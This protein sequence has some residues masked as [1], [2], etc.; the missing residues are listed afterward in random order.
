MAAL[1]SSPAPENHTEKHTKSRSNVYIIPPHLSPSQKSQYKELPEGGFTDVKVD[2][3]VGEIVDSKQRVWYFARYKGGIIRGFMA[4][5]F[6]STHKD[7]IDIYEEKKAAGLL[8]PF[9]PSNNSEVHPEHRISMTVKLDMKK[10][11]VTRLSISSASSS[12]HQDDVDPVPDSDDDE[13][14]DEDPYTE[15]ESEGPPRRSTRTHTK[16]QLLSP[17][18]LRRR[19]VFPVEDDGAEEPVAGTSLRRSGRSRKPLKLSLDDDDYE[20]ESNVD[21]SDGYASAGRHQSKAKSK[22]R[23][24]RAARAAYGQFRSMEEVDE[25]NV[26]PLMAHRHICE[27]CL[28]PPTTKLLASLKRKGKAKSRRR[29]PDEEDESDEEER[30]LSKGGWVRCLKCPVSAH[31]GCLAGTQ[32][33][34][35]L[36]AARQRDREQWLKAQEGSVDVD[37]DRTGP[38]KR[39]SL[40]VNQTTDFI[41]GSCMKG[42]FCMGCMETVLEPNPSSTQPSNMTIDQTS[43]VTMTDRTAQPESSDSNQLLFRCLTCKRLAHYEH[44]AK[45]QDPDED[46]TEL[47]R[48]H[49]YNWLCSDCVSYQWKLDK[50]LA[51]RPYPPNAVEPARSDTEPVNYKAPLPRQYLVKWQERGYR[52]TQWVPHMWLLTTNAQKLR[53]FILEG[54]K[55]KLLSEPRES[56]RDGTEDTNDGLNPVASSRESSVHPSSKTPRF[57]Q[58]PMPDAETKIPLEWQTIDRVLDVKLRRPLSRQKTKTSKRR[59]KDKVVESEVSEDEESHGVYEAAY[60]HSE[61]PQGYT[62][63]IEDFES[64][65][66]RSLNED[67]IER[68]IWGYFK[69]Q[70]LGYEEATNDSPPR[71]NDPTYPAFQKAFSRFIAARSVNIMKP[72]A[73][74]A[75]KFGASRRKKGDYDRYHTLKKAEDLAL[76]QDPKLKLMDFQVDGFNWLCRNWWDN[77]PCILA[78]E[79]GLGKTVQIASFIG[80]IVTSYKA[81]PMLVV[82][83]NS[84]VTN[85]VREFERWAPQLRVVPFYGEAKARDV[86]KAFELYHDDSRR[87]DMRTK[88]H[89]LITTYDTITNKTEFTPIFKNQPRWDTLV[90]DEGQRLKSDSSLLFKKLNELKVVHR[91]IM[92]G[93]PLNNNIRELFNLMNFLDPEQWNDLEALEKEHEELTEELIKQ[94]HER[95]RPYFLRRIK[96]AV[97]KLPPKVCP[98]A[99]IFLRRTNQDLLAERGK[100]V[101]IL[102][103]LTNPSASAQHSGGKKT[104]NNMLM[105]LRKCLQHPYLYDPDIEPRNLS[106]QETHEK[107]ID[108]SAKLRFLRSLLPKLKARGHRVLLFS[109]FVIALDVIEDFLVGEGI[110][111]LRLDGNTAGADR[112]KGMDEFNKEGS[113]VFIYL[114]TTRA[115]GVGINLFTA[116]T[117]VSWLALTDNYT[118]TL[119]K[120][121]FDPDFN[122][123]QDLQAI[124]RAH[125]FGQQKPVLVFKLTVKESAEERIMQIG[126]KK[127]VLDHL[128]VQKINDE[129]DAGDD[130]QSILMYGA[131]AL[132]DEEKEGSTKDIVY[133]DSDIDNLIERTEK[134]TQ[135]E[136]APKEGGLAFSFAKI[137]TSDKDQLEEVQDNDELPQQ[138]S[139]AKTLQKI[140]AEMELARS[141]EAAQ[142]GRGVRRKAAKRIAQPIPAYIEDTPMKPKKSRKAR[143][144]DGDSAYNWS[145]P[146]EIDSDSDSDEGDPEYTERARAISMAVD[147]P[148]NGHV[149]G[150]SVLP[151]PNPP[152]PAYVPPQGPCGLCGQNHRDDEECMML[153][154]SENLAEYREML[155]MHSEDE[156]WDQRVAAIRVIE[157]T[158]VKRGHLHLIRGQP[159]HPIRTLPTVAQKIQPA[160][161]P[162]PPPQLPVVNHNHTL[163]VAG[164]SRSSSKRSSPAG[165][166]VD[167]PKKKIK[168][169]LDV[170]QP[171]YLF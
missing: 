150:V 70:D 25:T 163:S 167:K 99:I 137:W 147:T 76:G 40:E 104:V 17:R 86:I 4:K 148:M 136:E 171:L 95:L 34:E 146:G 15:A 54:P 124:A 141:R 32:R 139:W 129:D 93:T 48:S 168:G 51:W 152:R 14:L 109:Q 29:D 94:L 82:V 59:T 16:A 83:P 113:E 60:D 110:K 134:E 64:R 22:K 126:K 106:P 161:P 165:D 80:K 41:C 122:P 63:T 85:W 100:N 169:S 66:G 75:S 140:N 53:N 61:E 73:F 98:L 112:Q 65:E 77:Q 36:K 62:E 153:E 142:S 96:S 88:F 33:E 158:L 166:A 133:S 72:S 6:L 49:H 9:D 149:N 97:L 10:R 105:Q 118:L 24:Y 1:S 164:P 46:L 156:P 31:W 56:G 5:D 144:S 123:H 23:V 7:L 47:A 116:D 57:P 90:I 159:L 117:V 125:R 84:T 45:D 92:T 71:P 74:D 81:A 79:M 27:K 19:K 131:Q 8:A 67:D 2:E 101:E 18:K 102:A 143:S 69:W 111:Y 157:E 138:D 68:V 130:L 44:L 38:S 26:D 108:A 37:M 119:L 151:A 170:I 114:L 58:A 127:M 43:D 162:P 35:I 21:D 154:K 115:G 13:A 39:S 52:R 132:F 12:R 78:D 91:I 3:V 120:I 121:I 145:E 11:R 20:G 89:V 30:V 160:P 103:G 128:I 50:I 107:L 87:R 155:I 135:V 55:V 28:E 42:G